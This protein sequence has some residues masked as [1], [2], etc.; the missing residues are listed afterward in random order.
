MRSILL[1]VS[2]DLAIFAKFNSLIDEALRKN[3]M[4]L[5]NAIWM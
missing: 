5:Q 3:D 2:P 4:E 1:D